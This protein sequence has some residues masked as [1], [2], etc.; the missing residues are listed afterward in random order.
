MRILRI[1]AL[2]G[3]LVFPFALAAE[4]DYARIRIPLICLVLSL[5]YLLAIFG[6]AKSSGPIAGIALGSSFALFIFFTVN[7][8]FSLIRLFPATGTL[9]FVLWGMVAH[10]AMFVAAILVARAARTPIQQVALY[11][12]IGFAYATLSLFAI[13]PIG[14]LF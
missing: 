1:A 2:S 9:A 6:P 8:F 3:L 4:T 11:A 14:T 12:C 5:P 13:K 7:T 10:G